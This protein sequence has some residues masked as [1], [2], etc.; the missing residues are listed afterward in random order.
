[1]KLAISGTELEPSESVFNL[2][3]A[4][5][6]LNVSFVE[7][8]YP[9]NTNK[10]GLENTIIAFSKAGLEVACISTGS[11]LYRQGGSLQDQ[12]LLIE[13]I[14]LAGRVKA[15]FANTYF[16]YSQVRDDEAAIARYRELLEPCIEYAEKHGVTIVLENEF[17]AFGVDND[18][19][20]I[21]R[22][23]LIL[24][25]L[26]EEVN[27]AFFRLN[28]DACNFYCAGI[29]P[30]PYAYELLRPFIAYCHVKDGSCYDATVASLITTSGWK[31]FVDF[32]KEFVMR[33]LGAG[34]IPWVNILRQLRADGYT[35]FI[36]L[37]P[38]SESEFRSQAW[39]Q[40]TDY[41]R[42]MWLEQ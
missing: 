28:F 2:I 3:E 36:T 40:A 33:P 9:R 32:D 38:H 27:S 41:V 39:R 15:P 11:E 34:A 29:E 14:E 7:L 22:R 1:L 17:N 20:D 19:S 21:T 42:K 13:A 26:F 25:R 18:A 16:G 8:W 12:S 5:H 31:R 23:P 24:R 37:E 35:G 10:E 4:A 30:F 6:E